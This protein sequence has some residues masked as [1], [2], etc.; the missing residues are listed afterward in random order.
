[1]TDGERIQ[2]VIA[3]AGVC[4]RRKAEEL[5]LEGRVTVNGEKVVELGMRVDLSRDEVRVDGSVVRPWKKQ[6]YIMMNKP[7]GIVTTKLDEKSRATVMDILAAAGEEIGALF[8]VGRLDLNSEG[9]L[10]ITNDGELADRLTSPRHHVTKTYLLRVRGVPGDKQLARLKEGIVLDG[11]RTLPIR[12]KIIGSGQNSWLKVWMQE[13]KKNQL[14]RMFKK[15][16]HPVV[17]L[18]R[19]A[20]GDL[21]LGD[22]EPGMFRRLQNHEVRELKQMTGL[23]H[24]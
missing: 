6:V 14:R 21:E 2:K 7:R 8:P 13:G 18:K 10:L 9:L 22:L 11:V 5:I 20:I 15:V 17:R 16:G 19:V 23:S 12:L 24:P 4:S 1:M 3:R